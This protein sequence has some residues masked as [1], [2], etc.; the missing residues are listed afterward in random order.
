MSAIAASE[1][2]ESRATELLREAT[3]WRLLG[4]LLERPRDGWWQELEMLGREVAD[5]EIRAAADAAREAANEGRYL[6]L[7][8]PGGPVSLREVTYR[9]ME[10]PGRIIADISGFYEAFAF[11]PETE[12]APDH[13]AVEAGFLGYLCLKEAYARA[14]GT[15]DEAE[16]AAQAAVR[17]REEHLSTLAWPVAERLAEA[18]A[19]YLSLAAAALARRAGPQP[20]T[21]MTAK[22]GMRSCD[23]CHMDCGLE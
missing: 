13:L 2:G 1:I 14:R 22:E 11:Q 18:D 10:D 23:D 4:L 3:A 15:E 19:R 6:A 9:G 8:G 21:T 5:P 16:V 17:F 7:V 20:V 12:E